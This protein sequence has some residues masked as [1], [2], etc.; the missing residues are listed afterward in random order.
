MQ[1]LLSTAVNGINDIET[2]EY[3]VSL[4]S[5]NHMAYT[6]IYIYYIYVLVISQYEYNILVITQV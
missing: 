2:Y 5:I 6:Y 4:S 1:K 3:C